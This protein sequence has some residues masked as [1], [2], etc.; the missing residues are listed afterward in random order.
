MRRAKVDVL[1]SIVPPRIYFQLQGRPAVRYDQREVSDRL[2]VVLDRSQEMMRLKRPVYYWEYF[3][4]R[5]LAQP[6]LVQHTLRTMSDTAL[7]R[8]KT[9]RGYTAC[10]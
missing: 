6:S 8:N 9:E 1:E 10:Y 2:A 3:R 4:L 5:I 7:Q